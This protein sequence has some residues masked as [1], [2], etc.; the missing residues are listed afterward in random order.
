MTNQKNGKI[1]LRWSIIG[2]FIVIFGGSLLHFAYEWSGYSPLVAMVSA[3]NESVWEHL[4][5]GFWSL[6]LYS[7]FEY[8]CIKDKAN[9]YF[10]AKAAGIFSMQMFI[11]VF[12]YTYT[13]LTK[14]PILL[15]DISSYV[16]GA[17]LCQMI[18]FKL[19]T[20]RGLQDWINIA[21]SAFLLLHALT[22]VVFTFAPPHLPIFQDSNT[23]QY[24]ISWK[25]IPSR[26]SH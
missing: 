18:S 6:V 21:G 15:V 17:M 8:W 5:L 7:S 14:H 25:V 19:M 24:G 4:K 20:K 26:T 10:A 12:F 13:A 11:V 23:D 9:N 2:A 16:A 22:L 1:V 3:A